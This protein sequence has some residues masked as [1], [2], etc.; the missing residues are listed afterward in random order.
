MKLCLVS[1]MILLFFI[2]GENYSQNYAIQVDGI[3][4]YLQVFD[5][6]SLDLTSPISICAWYYYTSGFSGEP[7][8]VQKD[9]D[10]S[11]GRYGIWIYSN[12]VDFCITP[13]GPQQCLF[14]AT[15]LVENTWNYIAAVFDG[16][17]MVVYI[18]AIDVASISFSLP[19]GIS[20]NTLYIGADP[21]ENLYLKGRIDEVTIWN[22]ALT[23][24]HISKFMSEVLQPDYYQ[25]SDSGLVAYYK[26][27]QY[28]NLGINNDGVDDIRDF[29]VNANHGDA[30]G[31]PVLVGS[32]WITTVNDESLPLEFSLSRNYPNP[33]NP[34]TTIVY[35][36]AQS[37]RVTL[38]IY[39]LLG[40]VVVKLVDEERP[41]GEYE[42]KWNASSFPS[43]VYF[44]KMQAGQFNETR[45]LLLMK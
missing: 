4:D 31:S 15:A 7:G 29:S 12:R 18:N 13:N 2:S 45:K 21:T 24:S 6:P 35:S 44:L 20:V 32:D 14:P 30:E 10:G 23:Q 1:V 36:L 28:E 22:R 27:D 38:S 19:A 40:R 33:F 34:S 37:G 41:A 16:V 26:F 17:K 8:L 42:T 3:D 11:W 9:G 39:D 5:H 43:G 25:S